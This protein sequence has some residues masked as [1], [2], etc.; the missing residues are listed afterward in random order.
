MERKEGWYWVKT[1]CLGRE[2]RVE[3]DCLYWCTEDEGEAAWLCAAGVD[4][5]DDVL[6]V[7]PRIPTPDEP[8]QCVPA[9]PTLEMQKAY[10]ESI[11]ENMQRGQ[12]DLR[13]GRFDNQRLGYQRMLS[14]APKPGD[15]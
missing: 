12:T 14:A 8:W 15:A 3:W 4:I 9:K 1:D 7:G 10:F 11:D 6:E 13:F 5:E 2:P